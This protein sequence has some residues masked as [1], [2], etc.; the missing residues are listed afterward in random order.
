MHDFPGRASLVPVL[1]CINLLT[2]RDINVTVV[3]IC[4]SFIRRDNCFQEIS[5]KGLKMKNMK[6]KIL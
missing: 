6:L 2:E 4:T 3:N 1:C 5:F